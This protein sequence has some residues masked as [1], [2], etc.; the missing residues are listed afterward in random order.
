MRRVFSA[1]PAAL[2]E[3]LTVSTAA[4]L[5]RREKIDDEIRSPTFSRRKTA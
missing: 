3:I 1:A 4:T 5:I 2:R